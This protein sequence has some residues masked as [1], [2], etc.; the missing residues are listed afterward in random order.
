MAE[1]AVE[2]RPLLYTRPA[3]SFVTSFQEMFH[4]PPGA[5]TKCLTPPSPAPRA[6]M[7]EV[8]G[9]FPF[10][11]HKH[12]ENYQDHASDSACLT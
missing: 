2:T 5:S 4:S 3:L 9:H 6:L 12:R 7:A 8:D 10:S 1:L 11:K